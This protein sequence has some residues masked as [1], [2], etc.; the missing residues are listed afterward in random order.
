MVDIISRI[1]SGR[2]NEGDQELL[3]QVLGG[4]TAF[5]DR[6]VAINGNA[7]RITIVTGNGN[8]VLNIIFEVGGVQIDDCWY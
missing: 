5:G 2:Q 8:V 7:E 4:T 3:L 6:T 1:A